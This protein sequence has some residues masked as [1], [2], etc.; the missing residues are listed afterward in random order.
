M[1]V[2]ARVAQGAPTAAVA[3]LGASRAR[4]SFVDRP[5]DGGDPASPPPRAW[6]DAHPSHALSVGMF[7]VSVCHQ[8]MGMVVVVLCTVSEGSLTLPNTIST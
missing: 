1:A 5:S 6:A 2:V 3:P 4:G 8:R 7:V